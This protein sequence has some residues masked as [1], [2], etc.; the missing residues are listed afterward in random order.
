MRFGCSAIKVPNHTPVLCRRGG[1]A[2]PLQSSAMA[3]RTVVG[4]GRLSKFKV[5][6]G[7]G[8]LPL[9]LTFVIPHLEK[10]CSPPSVS[11]SR[12]V[13]PEANDLCHLGSRT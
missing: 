12:P 9:P 10:D 3:S 6:A 1:S 2:R 4:W 13:Q 7:C 8:R 5:R 11:S